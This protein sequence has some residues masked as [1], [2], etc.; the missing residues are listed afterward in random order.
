MKLN[1]LTV[2]K[3]AHLLRTGEIT[4]LELTKACL[5]Q[6]KHVNRKINACLM[7]NEKN[8]LAQAKQA[9]QR[10]A[11]GEDTFLLGIPFLVKDNILT[12]NII[13]TAGS[14]MLKNYTAP[15]TATV[16]TRLET[17][18]AVLLGKTNLDEFAQGSSTE[19]SAFGVTKNPWDLKRVAGGSSGGSAAAVAADMCLFALGTDTGGSVRHPAAFCGVVGIKPTYGLCSRFGLMA[20][21]SSTD[22]PGILAKTA[23]DAQ[24]ILMIMQGEDKLDA[25]TISATHKQLE[26]NKK[27]NWKNIKIGVPKEYLTFKMAPEVKQHFTQTVETLKKLGATVTQVSLPLTPYAVAAYYVITPAE[28]SS[29]LARFDGIRFGHSAKEGKNLLDQYIKTREQGFGPE[30]KRRIMLGTFVLSAGYAEAYYHRAQAIRQGI[31]NEFKTVFKK[32]DLL[33]TPTTPTSAFK[34]GDKKNPLEMYLEDVFS[35]PASLAGLPAISVPMS[36]QPL[37]LGFQIIGNRLTDFKLLSL[38]QQLEQAL[39]IT[40]K[41]SC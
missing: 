19:Y 8:A 29:N 37:P 6:I 15:Y 5:K 39:K 16:V 1:E 21:T 24:K 26:I 35:V 12:K 40:G 22:V 33:V 2:T 14:K 27:V 25:T 36:K 31:I 13:T 38:A 20:M 28:I 11:Q 3:A 10:R 9:D 34:I 32:Y 17:A 18:G 7:L 4:S 41:P 30:V 23:E